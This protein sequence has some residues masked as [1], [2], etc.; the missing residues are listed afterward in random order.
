MSSSARTTSPLRTPDRSADLKG[1]QDHAKNLT[2]HLSN[3][4]HSTE[5]DGAST[6]GKLLGAAFVVVDKDGPIYS[7]ALGR[8]SIEATATTGSWRPDTLLWIA[9]LTKLI[10]ATGIMKLVKEGILSLEEDLRPLLPELAQQKILDDFEY[11]GT[12]YGNAVLFDHD[13]PITLRYVGP[14]THRAATY[15]VSI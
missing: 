10:S 13:N 3:Y 11:D 2:T 15:E 9:S 1:L 8:T 4:V 7:N 5:R 14:W 12:R 6:K